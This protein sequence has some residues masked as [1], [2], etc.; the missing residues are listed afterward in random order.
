MDKSESVQTPL[1]LKHRLNFQL[2]T[3]KNRFLLSLVISI[4]VLYLSEKS[5]NYLNIYLN[6]FVPNAPFLDSLKTLE[7]LRFSDVFKGY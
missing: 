1:S 2:K 6:P 7:T 5:R 4:R 3:S